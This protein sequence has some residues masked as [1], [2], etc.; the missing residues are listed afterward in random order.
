MYLIIKDHLIYQYKLYLYLSPPL[1]LFIF[2]LLFISVI[3][4]ILI[5]NS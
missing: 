2:Y 4:L 1:L 5:P 3:S